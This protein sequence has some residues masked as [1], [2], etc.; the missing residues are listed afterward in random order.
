MAIKYF[1]KPELVKP[2]M[3]ACWPGIGNV[4]LIAVESLR[5]HLRAEEFAEIEP[6]DFFYPRK[7]VI[8]A[9]VLERLDFP[10]SRFFYKR[11][12]DRDLIFFIGDEQPGDVG[13]TYAEGKKAYQMADMVMDVAEK[14]GCR[15]IYTSGAALYLTYHTSKP[16][17]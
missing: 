7:A 15:R 16:R 4:G 6:W 1:S 10:A 11:L 12:E 13:R 3:I 9:G 5:A 14:F 8:K 17:V 2:D